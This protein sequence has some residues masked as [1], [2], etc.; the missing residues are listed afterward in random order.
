MLPRGWAQN[1]AKASVPHARDD[2][3]LL[4][5]Q[6]SCLGRVEVTYTSA[7]KVRSSRRPSLVRPADTRE[8]PTP[9]LQ[10]P[11]QAWL[12]MAPVAGLH[13]ERAQVRPATTLHVSPL[14]VSQSLHRARSQESRECASG[15]QWR[16]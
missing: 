13:T 6:S 16:C 3:V 5:R 11:A 4:A 7:S 9:L 8:G 1:Q 2:V 15:K 10:K 12:V 14:E